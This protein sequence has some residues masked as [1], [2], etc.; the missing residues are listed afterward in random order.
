MPQ[1]M[2]AVYIPIHEGTWKYMIFWI[3]PIVDSYGA[4][5]MKYGADTN[6]AATTTTSGAK[7]F[8]IGL[9]RHER[10]EGPQRERDEH[11]VEGGE[12]ANPHRRG[13]F[14]GR[15]GQER[16]GAANSRNDYRNGD[17]IQQD[18]QQHIARACTHE[19]RGEQRADGAEAERAA[20]EQ[21][22]EQQ[23]AQRLAVAF[24]LEGAPER[25]RAGERDRDPQDAGGGVLDRAPFAHERE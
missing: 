3:S 7:A 14:V 13:G 16:R 17:W 1:T 9:F 2:I 21:R 20:G 19:H 6:S 23:R 11:H 18:W 22:R 15:G 10:F 25:E 4:W 12:D 5:A 8:R 24:A